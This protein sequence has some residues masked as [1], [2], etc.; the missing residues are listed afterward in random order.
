VRLRDNPELRLTSIEVDPQSS[1]RR[2][3]GRRESSFALHFLVEGREAKPGGRNESE[4]CCCDGIPVAL[5]CASVSRWAYRKRRRKIRRACGWRCR[6][7]SGE[8]KCSD[9]QHTCLLLPTSFDLALRSKTPRGIEVLREQLVLLGISTA[10]K[11]FMR[12]AEVED[13]APAASLVSQVVAKYNVAAPL[14]RAGRDTAGCGPCVQRAEER[15]EHSHHPVVRLGFA[16][17]HGL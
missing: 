12:D 9:C 17:S 2:R 10:P 1:Q 13:Q 16:F 15:A 14:A 3:F 8:K 7:W 5:K 6:Q 11:S 4:L